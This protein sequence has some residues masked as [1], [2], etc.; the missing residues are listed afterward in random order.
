VFVMAKMTKAAA[1]KR[2]IEAKQ[3]CLRVLFDAPIGIMFQKDMAEI[4]KILDR[5]INRTK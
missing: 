3:K 4:E 2:M 1:R 5:V